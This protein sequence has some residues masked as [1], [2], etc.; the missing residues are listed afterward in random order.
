MISLSSGA[1][2][3]AD[4]EGIWEASSNVSAMVNIYYNSVLIYGNGGVGSLMACQP[5]MFGNRYA[6][7]VPST[8]KNNILVLT[9][10]GG[11]NSYCINDASY[12]TAPIVSDYNDLYAY[13]D[14]SNTANYISYGPSNPDV[15]LAQWQVTGH[16][17]NSISVMPNF[18]SNTDLHIVSNANIAGHGIAISVLDDID[19]VARCAFPDPGI[20]Q[21]SAC[22][23]YKYLNLTVMLESLY[24]TNGYMNQVQGPAGNEYSGNTADQVT[25]ELHSSSNYATI[26]TSFTNVPIPTSGNTTIN[27]PGAYTGS[28]YITIVPRNGIV[29]VSAAPVSFAGSTT[30]YNFTT[31]AAQAYG[32]NLKLLNSSQSY[33]NPIY[34]IYA[35]DVNNDGV[36]DVLDI[37]AV[38]NDALRFFT[39]FLMTDVNGDGAVDAFDINMV[40][41]NSL[42]FV[43]SVTP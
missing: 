12:N 4:V 32:K 35:G 37:A 43:T 24:N 30:N 15:N 33:A 36:V 34:G 26:V 25:V 21:F 7:T 41:N 11:T 40:Q 28:Y 42:L 38:Q 13:R 3:P 20:N 6:I 10:T 39:G 17:L 31:A 5:L 27:V 22:T 1:N 2:G 8:I 16:D 18:T 29:T 23:T 19:G 9:R 14:P